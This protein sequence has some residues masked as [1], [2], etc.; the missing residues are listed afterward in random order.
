MAKTEFSVVIPCRNQRNFIAQAVESVLAQT[1]AAREVIV[2]DDASTDGSVDVLKGY[3]SQIRLLAC[4]TNR[5]AAGARNAGTELAQG[6]YIAYLDGDDAFEPWALELYDRIIQARSPLM[7]L[8]Q[9]SFFR[10]R[11]PE[12]RER[13][14]P[15]QIELVSYENWID[16]DREFRSSASLIVVK[17]SAVKEVGGWK[18]DAWPFDDYFLLTDLAY[19]GRTI[20][21]LNP[22]TVLYREHQNNVTHNLPQILPGTYRYIEAALSRP[23]LKNQPKWLARLALAGGQPLW[24]VRKAWQNGRKVDALRL[25]FRA[26]PLIAATAIVRLRAM[27]FGR[28]PTEIFPVANS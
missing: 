20:R 24:A 10:D 6:E 9:M 21:I 13:D 23:H 15:P 11:F 1:H 4:E 26:S 16:K 25:L 7:V 19:S 18:K 28:R 8:A 27:V 17:R 14:L 3:G 22:S 12:N 5:G 2:V